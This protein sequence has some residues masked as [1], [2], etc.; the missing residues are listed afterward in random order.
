[1][2]FDSLII[3]DLSNYSGWNS[4]SDLLRLLNSIGRPIILTCKVFKLESLVV[5]SWVKFAKEEFI[6]KYSVQN[7]IVFK[8]SVGI[9]IKAESLVE[10]GHSQS[11]SSL[12]FKDLVIWNLDWTSELSFNNMLKVLFNIFKVDSVKRLCF[13]FDDCDSHDFI[14]G[15]QVENVSLTH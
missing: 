15:G 1:M 10:V 7:R 5:R 14:D 4:S 12:S 3:D 11:F 8:E 13:V 9:W 2:G 6:R